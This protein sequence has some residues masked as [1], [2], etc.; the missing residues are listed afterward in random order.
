MKKIIAILFLT[1]ASFAYVRLQN[2][3]GAYVYW[4]QDN[5]PIHFENDSSYKNHIIHAA[6]IWL[7]QDSYL[8][9]SLFAVTDTGGYGLDISPDDSI[10]AVTFIDSTRSTNNW[11]EIYEEAEDSLAFTVT[12]TADYSGRIVD[13]DIVV[14]V[15]RVEDESIGAQHIGEVVVHEMGH[16]IGLDHI[17]EFGGDINRGIPDCDP[18]TP[19]YDDVPVMYPDILPGDGSRIQLT[20]DDLEGLLAI[21]R[22]PPKKYKGCGFLGAVG[23]EGTSGGTPS[24]SGIFVILCPLL[25]LLFLKGK[26]FL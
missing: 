8:T 9:F 24:A 11:F 15:D 14:G 21:Y 19:P 18:V 23:S 7:D 22:Y 6:S 12:T 10:N 17:C 1:T 5:V 20:S 25:M 16:F 2:N 13:S 4:G 26:A 3:T